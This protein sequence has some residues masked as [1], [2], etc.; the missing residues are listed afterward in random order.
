[1]NWAKMA[2]SPSVIASRSSIENSY[3]LGERSQGYFP[4]D[5]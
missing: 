4:C 3:D 2:S 5:R 1:M